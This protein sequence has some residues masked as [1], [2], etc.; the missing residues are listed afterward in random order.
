MPLFQGESEHECL[1]MRAA[2]VL[3]PPNS[4]LVDSNECIVFPLDLVTSLSRIHDGLEQARLVLDARQYR[5]LDDN[6]LVSGRQRC[7]VSIV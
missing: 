7:R 5:S 4:S 1:T 2:D 3:I 6:D